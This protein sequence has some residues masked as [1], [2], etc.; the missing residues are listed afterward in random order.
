M[1]MEAGLSGTDPAE[2]PVDYSPSWERSILGATDALLAIAGALTRR[3][4]PPPRIIDLSPGAAL[5]SKGSH[6]RYRITKINLSG[7]IGDVLALNYGGMQY[8]WIAGASPATFDFPLV[9]DRGVDFSAS[10]ITTPAS[11]AWRFYVIGYPE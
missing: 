6:V 11:T 9:L 5:A 10:N 8:Q 7:A 1:V 4:E 2:V 3:E